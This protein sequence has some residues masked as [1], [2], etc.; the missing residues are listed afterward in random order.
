MNQIL[1]TKLKDNI[2]DEEKNHHLS[3]IEKKNWFRFQ[4]IFSTFIMSISILCGSFY[5]Y[6]LA[7]KED[8]SKSLIANYN[9]ARLYQ[10]KNINENY[11]NQTENAN[12]LFRNYP[13]T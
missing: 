3:L 7:K 10:E 8:F 11:Q 6:N 4:F 9:I 12:N 5:I 13:N 2:D 1:S